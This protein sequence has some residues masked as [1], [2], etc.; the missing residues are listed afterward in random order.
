[1]R[2][3]E[4]AAARV[5]E[6]KGDPYAWKWLLISLHN[7]VQ[8]VLVLALWNGNGLLTLKPKTAQKWLRALEGGGPF[9]SDRL[10]EFLNLYLKAKEPI[11]F[12]RVGS[13]AFAPGPTHDSSLEKLNEFRNEFTHFTPKG[14]SLQLAGLPR[15]CLDALDVVRHFAWETTPI[16][17]YKAGYVTRTKRAHSRLRKGLEALES[18]YAD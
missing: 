11:N 9:P 8:G 14:W 15:I 1:M 10:D 17:W 13:R 18:G 4:W 3:L 16:N 7:A 2:S 6:I 12:H 5:Q